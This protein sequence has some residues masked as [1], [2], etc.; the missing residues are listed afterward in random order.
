MADRLRFGIFLAPFHPPTQNPTLALERDLELVVHLDRL[1]YDEAWFGEHHSC[2]SELI[3]SP[4]IFI[5][6]AAERTRHIRLGTGVLSLPYH[7]PLWVADR[8]ILLDHL[9]RGRA[10]LGVG[11]GALPTDARMIG[12]DP[13]DQRAALEHDMDVLMHLLRSDEPISVETDR[14][15][16]V[17]AQTQLRPYSDPCF[18]VAVAAIASPSG[19]RIA[20]KHGLGLLSVGATQKIG[21]DA[22]ALHWSVME[23]RAAEFGSRTDRNGWRLVGPMY[24]AETRDQAI[25]DVQ[26]GLD[27]WF[28]YLQNSA[29]A[30]QFSPGG[31][32]F[33]ERVDWVIESGV[34]IIGTVEDAAAQIDGLVKQSGG[35]GAFLQMAHEW[36][37]PDNIKKSYELIARYV[38]P[39][40]QGSAAGIERSDRKARDLRPQLFDQQAAAL[41][42]WTEKHA[43]ERAEKGG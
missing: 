41:A 23:E 36:A 20:G 26:F 1:G 13:A 24:V 19:P 2:G 29:A 38:F 10:M 21:F 30:P 4:E 7:N 25:K 37:T 16:L 18:E 6:V 34:G 27:A 12:I 32:T 28:D 42:A 17:E 15:R 39:Q 33:K 43:K 22:L 3:A 14:Y 40:F 31:T 5:A 35:F 8:M 11:P 9:T